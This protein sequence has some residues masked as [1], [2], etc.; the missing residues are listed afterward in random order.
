MIRPAPEQMQDKELNV[1]LCGQERTCMGEDRGSKTS[2]SMEAGS[3]SAQF[4]CK[5]LP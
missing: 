1:C 4:C 3:H 2:I 5:T